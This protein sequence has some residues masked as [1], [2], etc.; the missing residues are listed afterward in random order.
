[1]V[2]A[3]EA[4][5]L[6]LLDRVVPQDRLAAEARALAQAWAAQPPEA[7]GRAKEALYESE[8]SSLVAMLDRE[9][10][11]QNELFATPAVRERIAGGASIAKRSR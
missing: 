1:M 10:A 2:P 7:V 9:I 5:E 4:L 3:G 11:Q 8:V 6:G